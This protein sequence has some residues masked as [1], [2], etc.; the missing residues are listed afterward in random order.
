MIY[1]T[2]KPNIKVPGTS[3]LFITFDYK[4]TVIDELKLLPI[5]YYNPES[6][7]WEIPSCSLSEF[8]DRVC[9][10]DDITI[11]L[12]SDKS[13][14]EDKDYDLIDYPTKPF[15]YQLD[16]I[17]YGLN[18]DSWLLLDAPG[19]GKS[20]QIIYLAEE[21]KKREGL[22][23]CLIICGINTLKTNWKKEIE[24]HS[25][26]DCRILGQRIN[27]KGKF[28]VDGI[29]KRLEQL[30]N[31]IDEFFVILNIETLRDDRII[32][33]LIKNKYNKFDMI[34]LDEA[35]V[36]K[37]PSSQQGK[38]LLKLTKSKHKIAATGTLLLNNP[39]DTYV[40]LKWIGMERCNYSNFKHFYCNYGGPFNNILLGY[41]NITTL[42]DQ[43]DKCSLRRTKD[44]LGLPPKTVI[45]E[46]IDMLPAQETFYNNIKDGII[47]QVDKVHMSTANLL[48][49]IARFRQATVLPSI[50][51]T[52][53]IPSAKLERAQ[54]LAEQLID[55]GEKVVIFSTYKA[56]VYE[57]KDILKR[58]K[59]V[60]VTGDEDEDSIS[61]AIDSFQTDP[62]V[63]LFL[64]TWSKAG[65]GITL[66][67]ASYMIFLDTPWTDGVFQ[68]AQDRI[69]RIGSNKPVFIYNLVTKDTI[70]ERVLEIVTD[71][72]A[73]ASY[74]VDDEI[75]EQT[76]DSLRKYIAEL[77]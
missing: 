54:D 63:K 8:I 18:H 16:G 34:A 62:N 36:V 57:L 3:S 30:N 44:I 7:E 48:A 23:H 13:N 50:L 46:Y 12:L 35:H 77:I 1:I 6:K 49:C 74:V 60:V 43:L 70:D 41:R 20:L 15:E 33:S 67:A 59:P 56:P 53:K 45:T 61:K 69:H 72:K 32:K 64:G 9:A 27:R 47:S 55:S 66:N 75:T 24:K 22:E 14:K 38:H 25:N 21:L 68:Q 2:E 71:K 37:N 52:D 19:L 76:I 31:P 51:T 26:L 39:V 73:I 40:P 58:Y 65:T 29:D 28:V 10:Y 42:K 5:Y 17:K 11:K 4:Q